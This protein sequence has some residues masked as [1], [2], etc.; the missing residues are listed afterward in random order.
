[1]ER[2]KPDL[3]RKTHHEEAP[4]RTGLC[5]GPELQAA[6]QGAAKWL[7]LHVAEVNSLNVFPVPDGDTGTNMVL[8]MEAALKE[9]EEKPLHGAGE[10]AA[11]F[12]HGALMGA[13]GN[14][15]VILSQIIRG[16]ARVL[17]GRETFDGSILAEALQ[18]ATQT[19]YRAV[20]KPVE[21]T[22][23]TVIR[24]CAEAA[25]RAARHD[26]SLLYVLKEV[27]TEAWE[28]VHQTPSLLPILR[29][30]DDHI[31]LACEIK[32]ANPTPGH[33]LVI[34]YKQLKLFNHPLFPLPSHH[35]NPARHQRQHEGEPKGD[36]CC[37]GVHCQRANQEGDRRDLADG[38]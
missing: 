38:F 16:M 13:R 11:A 15:G 10:V 37:G 35:I 19:A 33:W 22:I 1:M 30:S 27:V 23:L 12:S 8:T 7:S 36:R 18:A 2:G 24:D 26:P 32:G 3:T 20:S 17:E 14:S 9:A 31:S 28:S 6:F 25:I 5:D 21:G 29:F 4:L 34:H